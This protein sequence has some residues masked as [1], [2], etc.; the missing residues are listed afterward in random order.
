[1]E[2][3]ALEEGSSGSRNCFR[4]QEARASGEGGLASDER[5]ANGTSVEAGNKRL[6]KRTITK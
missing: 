1:M 5:G 2:K 6:D 3:T 4:S